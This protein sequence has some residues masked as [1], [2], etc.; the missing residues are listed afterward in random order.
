MRQMR[1]N[2]YACESS[3]TAGCA[4]GPAGARGV[5]GMGTRMQVALARVAASE[6]IGPVC[7]VQR[8]TGGRH[9]GPRQRRTAGPRSNSAGAEM[10]SGPPTRLRRAVSNRVYAD[11]G[12]QSYRLPL[13][14][15]NRRSK[16]PFTPT[17]H[18]GIG[19]RHSRVASG[20]EA[21]LRRVRPSARAC[22][23][24]ARAHGGGGG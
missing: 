10:R 19:R 24:A 1:V 23:A 3:D 14:L 21:Y 17:S 15:M 8:N 20:A 22:D 11:L 18:K 2:A 9:L 5:Q 13:S 4:K 7:S 16:Q 12:C 6:G